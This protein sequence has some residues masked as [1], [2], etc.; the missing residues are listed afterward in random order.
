[1]TTDHPN[2][3]ETPD[4]ALA[5]AAQNGVHD[6][7]VELVVRYQ[8][9]LHNFLRSRLGLAVQC[10]D[11]VQEIF[12]RAWR[13]LP[14]YD[15]RRRFRSWIFTIAY[16][17]GISAIRRNSIEN[18][19]ALE[20]TTRGGDVRNTNTPMENLIGAEET[21]NLWTLAR[22]LLPDRQ[23]TLLWLFYIEEMEGSQMARIMGMTESGVKVALHR[24][25]KRLKAG[26]AGQVAEPAIAVKTE[27][28]PGKPD[29]KRPAMSVGETA[30]HTETHKT[31]DK[32][33]ALAGALTIEHTPANVARSF[34]G[35]I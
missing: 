20:Q 6:A 19:C 16:R 24:A 9:P 4:E 35:D 15:S 34:G 31:R 2:P 27:A 12:L 18:R 10:E 21:M 11:L 29:G 23:I 8:A 33:L 5:I 22:Q 26:S 3:A 13:N 32:Y 14:H 28:I 30:V 7:F 25:R 17:M 1:M